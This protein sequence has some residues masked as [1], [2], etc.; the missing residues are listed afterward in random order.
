MNRTE[1]YS[2]DEVIDEQIGV[3]G[4]QLRAEFDD[5]IDKFLIGEAI[6][7]A[8]L[9]KNLTQEELGKMVGVQRAQISRIERGSTLSIS[10][11]SKV[12][13]AMGI[14]A[15]IVIEGIGAVSLC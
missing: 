2:L 9:S 12:F 11:V 8:R 5:E 15:S 13:R 3:R 7:R 4:S 10:T 1:F 14:N 6:R